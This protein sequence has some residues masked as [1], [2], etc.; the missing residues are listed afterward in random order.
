[1]YAAHVRAWSL[2]CG[3]RVLNRYAQPLRTYTALRWSSWVSTKRA[4][5][6]PEK[7]KV[8]IPEFP[9]APKSPLVYVTENEYQ[10]YVK[11]LF[12]Y[13]WSLKFLRRNLYLIDGELRSGVFSSP[14]LRRTLYFNGTEHIKSFVRDINEIIASEKHEPFVSIRTNDN[15]PDVYQVSIFSNTHQCHDAP[16]LLHEGGTRIGPGISLLDARIANLVERHFQ[17]KYLKPGHGFDRPWKHQTIPADVENIKKMHL[18]ADEKMMEKELSS[19]DS[20]ITPDLGGVIPMPVPEAP[21][22]VYGETCTDDDFARVI[23]PLYT[24]G[25]YIVYNNI[26]KENDS[27]QVVIEKHP[28]LN[29]FYRFRSFDTAVQF[30]QDVI[31]LARAED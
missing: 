7:R 1:M 20:I 2:S 31:D 23:S 25:W 12:W 13:R 11:P 24:R 6:I 8:P 19:F 29:G 15:N 27:G 4:V 5:P 18:E 17:E 3:P 21:L 22:R 30:S 9:P 16:S 28:V 26:P 10:T 14:H